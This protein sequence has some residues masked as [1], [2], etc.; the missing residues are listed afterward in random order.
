MV[1]KLRNCKVTAI[2]KEIK[3]IMFLE[4]NYAS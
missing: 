4:N 2:T 1:G 3:R